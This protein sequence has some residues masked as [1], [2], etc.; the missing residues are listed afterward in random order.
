VICRA[1]IVHKQVHV[2]SHLS[3]FQISFDQVQRIRVSWQVSSGIV[4]FCLDGGCLQTFRCTLGPFTGIDASGMQE[5]VRAGYLVTDG[6]SALGSGVTGSFG[7]E[8]KP[9][10]VLAGPGIMNHL[11]AFQDTS[12]FDRT[13]AAFRCYGQSDTFVFPVVEIS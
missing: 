3:F 8:V 7:F 1:V 10:D 4:G 12:F 2:A 5:T 6:H 11:G 9:H 13:S